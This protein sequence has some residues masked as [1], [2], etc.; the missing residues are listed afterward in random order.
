MVR[1]AADMLKGTF[2]WFTSGLGRRRSISSRFPLLP[3]CWR[4]GF[5]W[6]TLLSVLPDAVAVLYV[7]VVLLSV[8]FLR[9]RG[10]LLVS[11]G[12]AALTVLGYLL[13]HGLSYAGDPFVRLL[14]SLS[15]I[16]ATA[17]LALKN[18]SGSGRV[19]TSRRDFW[20]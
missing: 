3:G 2:A 13:Q 4:S 18:Q 14:V 19:A 15:A 11:L 16:G 6:S 7:V 1:R 17:F 5:S 9:W 20:T 10:V 8:N 12:C